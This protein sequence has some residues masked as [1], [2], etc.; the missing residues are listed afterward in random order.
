MLLKIKQGKTFLY[1]FSGTEGGSP[2]SALQIILDKPAHVYLILKYILLL[3]FWNVC[4]AT[5]F[6]QYFRSCRR[7]CWKFC[8][9][10]VLLSWTYA[11]QN[12]MR[13]RLVIIMRVIVFT[14]LLPM[15]KKL[16]LV[17]VNIKDDV[18]FFVG[19][20]EVELMSWSVSRSFY[21]WYIVRSLCWQEYSELQGL[22]R[23]REQGNTVL[24]HFMGCVDRRAFWIKV[25]ITI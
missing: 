14:I 23:N 11:H 9:F 24:I 15:I 21:L 3:I 5:V 25:H 4:R 2:F 6:L 16:S 19:Y 17:F 22:S 7:T 13:E 18:F 12:F 1:L 20:W 10:T 8:F